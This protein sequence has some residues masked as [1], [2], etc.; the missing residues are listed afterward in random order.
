MPPASQAW[1]AFP[2][3][4]R[5]LSR[6]QHVPYP[7]D[8]ATPAA[9]LSFRPTVVVATPGLPAPRAVASSAHEPPPPEALPMNLQCPGTHPFRHK[10]DSGILERPRGPHAPNDR[11]VRHQVRPGGLLSPSRLT[12]TGRV[13]PFLKPTHSIPQRSRGGPRFFGGPFESSG[14]TSGSAQSAMGLS[15]IQVRPSPPL[16][17]SGLTLLA[18]ELPAFLPLILRPPH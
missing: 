16:P 18:L 13:C 4:P 5:P 11:I 2:P 14:W 6:R 8:R 12:P 3:F 10:N 7:V 9:A 1:T 15:Q 17:F